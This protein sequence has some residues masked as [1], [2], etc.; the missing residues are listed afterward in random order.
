MSDQ[1]ER[2]PF[3]LQRGSQNGGV[4]GTLTGGSS[5]GEVLECLL[6]ER[7]PCFGIAVAMPRGAQLAHSRRLRTRVLARPPR[8][9]SNVSSAGAKMA[10]WTGLSPGVRSSAGRLPGRSAALRLLSFYTS[11][12]QSFAPP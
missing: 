1:E 4:D 5:A 9:V 6:C 11:M 7:A 10:G 12:T 8:T 2:G 3:Q